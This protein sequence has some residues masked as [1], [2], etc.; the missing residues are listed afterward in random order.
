[1]NLKSHV[2]LPAQLAQQLNVPRCLVP[3]VEVVAF[4]NFP[5][6]KPLLKN[7]MGKLVRRHQRKIARE[8]EQQDRID[9][10]G[11]QESQL[12]RKRS[13][14]LQVVIGPQ[15]AGGVGIKGDNHRLPAPGFRAPHDFVQNMAVSAVHTVEVT[16]ADERGTEIAGNI[17]EFV[18]SSHP[19]YFSPPRRRGRQFFLNKDFLGGLGVPA[20]NSNL[21]SQTPASFRQ[22][23]AAPRAATWRWWPR[24]AGRDRCA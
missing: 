9:A 24:V 22:T 10:G 23:P 18:E 2:F 7:F 19:D 5:G 13:Q 4:V 11:F 20:V 21:K 15:D 17:V 14:Q 1:V 12:F 16:N 8:G 3:E 6:M